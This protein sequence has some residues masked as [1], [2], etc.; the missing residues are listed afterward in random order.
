MSVALYVAVFV[1][2]GLFENVCDARRFEF[3]SV[4]TI[5][6]ARYTSSAEL[7]QLSC[8]RRGGAAGPESARTPTGRGP[9]RVG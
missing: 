4:K 6:S 3:A 1:K 8:D 9:H 7:A 5:S 2:S